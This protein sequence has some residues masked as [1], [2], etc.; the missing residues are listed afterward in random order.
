MRNV[1]A[2]YEVTCFHCGHIAHISPD[3]ERCAVCGAD[4]KHLITPDYASRYF[5]DRAAEMAAAGEV[6]LALM[7]VERGLVYRRS[8]ELNLL[9]AILSQRLGNFE[10]MRR[11]VAAIPVDDVLRPEAEWLLRSQQTTLQAPRQTGKRE[12]ADRQRPT[13]EIAPPV[14][15]V[16]PPVP[17]QGSRLSSFFYGAVALLL[18]L[19]MGWVAFGPGAQVLGTLFPSSAPTGIDQAAPQTDPLVDAA[20]TPVAPGQTPLTS[21]VPLTPVLPTPTSDVPPNLVQTTPEPLAATTPQQAVDALSGQPYDLKSYLLQTNRP[22]LADLEVSATVQGVTLTLRGIVSMFD[23][24]Q[25]LL[26]LAQGAPN[27]SQVNAIDLIVRLPPTYT[28]QAGDTMW[29]IS[30][31]LYGDNRIAQ[32]FNANRDILASP[33]ALSVG[34]VLKVPE[35]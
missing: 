6:T 18:L 20:A 11:Y 28:V 29:G 34:Q 19:F 16:R 17:A 26:D 12:Q 22:D 4:L 7:E 31:K 3:A 5:Y 21:T 2:M 30:Y 14:W 25:S 33:E 32:I 13:P 8:P 9:A 27:V 24:R 1:Q 35:E 10:Q 15:D 23:Q